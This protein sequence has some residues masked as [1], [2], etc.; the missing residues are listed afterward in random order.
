MKRKPC[1]LPFRVIF[2]PGMA[3]PADVT[4][5]LIVNDPDSPPENVCGLQKP[6]LP[7]KSATVL[8][9]TLFR[10]TSAGSYVVQKPD[11]A[12]VYEPG[13]TVKL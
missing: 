3:W 9:D 4:V 6:P 7:T 1:V 10:F 5:P 11:G 13:L 12:T 8:A 2:A